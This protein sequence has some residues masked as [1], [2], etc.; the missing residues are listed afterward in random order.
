MI[1]L[2]RLAAAAAVSA[3]LTT[4]LAAAQSGSIDTTG[5][6]SNN[7]VHV[8]SSQDVRVTNNN[9]LNLRNTNTQRADTGRADVSNNTYGGS[10]MSG[11]ASNDNSTDATVS[12]SNSSAGSLGSWVGG[13]GG[14]NDVSATMSDTGPNSH[15]TIDASSSTNVNLTNNNNVTVSNTSTQ[16]ANSGNA[17]VSNNTHGGDAVSGD[18]SNTN[19]SSFDISIDN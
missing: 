15:N 17:T 3:S 7:R 6:N 10:A 12:V 13:G 2:L 5:P 19:S 1:K 9:R 18:A 8:R 16:T 11:N 14:G 4:G